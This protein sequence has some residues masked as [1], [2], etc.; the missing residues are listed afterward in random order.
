MNGSVTVTVVQVVTTRDALGRETYATTEQDVD[1]VMFAPLSPSERP[2][3]Q[4]APLTVASGTFYLPVALQLNADDVI[5]HAGHE[6]RVTGGSQVWIDQTE[7]QA[8][9]AGAFG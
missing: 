3:D 1:D 4:G 5:L 8:D 9:R 2:D 7:A 6:W